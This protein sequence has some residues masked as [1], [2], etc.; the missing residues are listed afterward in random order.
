MKW[1]MLFR[2]FPAVLSLAV[3]A[4]VTRADDPDPM[5]PIVPDL[6]GV[7]I[8]GQCQ[9]S[10]TA[11]NEPLVGSAELNINGESYL[12][13]SIGEPLAVAELPGN[14][15][16]YGATT[17]HVFDLGDNNRLMTMDEEFLAPV[18]PGAFIVTGTMNIVGGTGRY[19]TARGYLDVYGLV[20]LDAS[21]V[22]AMTRVEGRIDY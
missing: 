20:T 5:V 21:S 16:W 1:T 4:T 7:A 11:R 17:A 8:V 19:G 3:M 10:A 13:S 6:P 15:G 9:E 14:F 22:N 18:G 12:A 2:L